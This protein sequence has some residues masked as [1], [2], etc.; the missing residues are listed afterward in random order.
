MTLSKAMEVAIVE[1][2]FGRIYSSFY[3]ILLSDPGFVNGKFDQV[4]NELK[5]RNIEGLFQKYDEKSFKS[6]EEWNQQYWDSLASELKDNFCVERIEHLKE[7]SK[8][9]Y[10]SGQPKQSSVNMAENE[11]EAQK[12]TEQIQLSNHNRKSNI[13]K[14]IVV[15]GVLVIILILVLM[16]IR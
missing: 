11:F 14:L 3:T 7:V 6:K 16:L 2:D 4:L 12:K 9:L 1:K 13:G 15:V 8:F 5:M 10:P